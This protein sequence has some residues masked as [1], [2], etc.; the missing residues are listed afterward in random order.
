MGRPISGTTRLCAVIGDPVDHSLSPLLHNA[1]YAALGLDR[2]FVALRVTAAGLV[3]AVAGARALGLAGLSVTTPH[4]EAI[5]SLLDELDP[6]AE[7]LGAVNTVAVTADGGLRGT[8]TDGAGVVGALE[9]AGAE[10]E[11]AA[12]LVLGAGGA[13]K[14]ATEALARAGAARVGVW[15]R[16]GGRAI[17]VCSLAGAVGEAVG[18]PDPSGWDLVVN[19]TSVGM[20]PGDPNP[21]VADLATGQV[22]VEMVYAA[23]PS[24]LASAA[25]AAGAH[26]VDGET[27][28]L[29]QAVAAFREHTGEIAPLGYLRT[30]L[31]EAQE[32]GTMNR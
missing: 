16:R 13:A 22:V 5:V 27:V 21:L 32:A 25:R 3:A 24:E 20:R 31:R 12:C 18:E 1:G 14:A 17:A 4:K 10:I 26:L 6:L 28:L 7:T 23:G 30:A 15:A 11:G 8:N 9:E 29:H 19:A 2:A